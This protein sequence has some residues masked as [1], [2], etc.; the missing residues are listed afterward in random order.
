MVVVIKMKIE[1]GLLS[2]LSLC[3]LVFFGIQ[4]DVE[5]YSLELGFSATSDEVRVTVDPVWI[6]YLDFDDIGWHSWSGATFGNVMLL[7]DYYQTHSGSIFAY[8]FNHVRQYRALN[9]LIYPA[10]LILPIEA[11][12]LCTVADEWLP[13]SWWISQWRFL[14]VSYDI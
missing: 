3:V 1:F 5:L 13:P 10:Q 12:D 6:V 4:G 11:P 14:S 2:I 8:E 7:R 9:W